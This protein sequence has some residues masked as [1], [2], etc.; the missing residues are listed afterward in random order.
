MVRQAASIRSIIREGHWKIQGNRLLWL[1]GGLLVLVLMLVLPAYLL[2]PEFQEI[3]DFDGEVHAREYGG[4]LNPEDLPEAPVVEEMHEVPPMEEAPV[5]RRLVAANKLPELESRLPR[6]PLVMEGSPEA[7]YGGTLVN[8]SGNAAEVLRRAEFLLRPT[9]V[10]WSPGG[11]PIRPWLAKSWE[12][13]E[14][15]TEWTFHLRRGVQ[16]SD[17]HPLTTRGFAYAWRNCLLYAEG[18]AEN[19]AEWMRT[20]G[21]VAAFVPVQDYCFKLVFKH[22]KPLLLERLTMAPKTSFGPFPAPRH[23]LQ[24]FHWMD[25]DPDKIAAI[26]KATGALEPIQAYRSLSRVDNPQ[27]PGLGPWIY[28]RFKSNPPQSYVRNPY[29]F[30]VDRHGRQLPYIDQL[31]LDIRSPKLLPVSLAAGESSFQFEDI[32]EKDLSLLLSQQEKAGYRIHEWIPAQRS[33]WTIWPNLNRLVHENDPVSRMKHDLLNDVRFR[34]ALSLA[35]NR[36]RIIEGRYHGIGEPAQLSPPPDS[37]LY[38]ETLQHRFTEYA[39]ARAD[40]LLDRIGLTNRDKE[41]YRTFPDGSRMTWFLYYTVD[42]GLGPSA[43]VAEDWKKV[44]IRLMLKERSRS[45]FFQEKH[46]WI[47]DFVA[48]PGETESFPIVQPRSFVPTSQGTHFAVGFA[49]WFQEGGLWHQQG[50]L[51]GRAVEPPPGHPLRRALEI[52]AELI[53]SPEKERREALMKEILAIAAENVWSISIAT[54]LPYPVLVDEDLRGVPETAR[55]SYFFRSPFNVYPER[56]YFEHS[57]QSPGMDRE[58]EDALREANENPLITGSDRTRM[59]TGQ[60]DGFLNWR[61]G[62]LLL[63]LVFTGLALKRYPYIGKRLLIMVPTLFIISLIIFAIIQLPPGS[64]LETRK[65][66]MMTVGDQAALEYVEQLEAMFLQDEPVWKQYA[67]WVGLKWFTTFEERDRGLLQGNLGISMESL[68]PVNELVGDRILLTFGV[69]LGTILFT[70]VIA[71]PVGVY[72][73]VRQYSFGDY[74]FTTL[75]FLGMCIPNFLLAIILIAVGDA[76]FGATLT[77]LFS[78]EYALQPEWTWDKF[79]DLLKHIWVPVL[80]LG[81]AGTGGMIRVMRANLLD[82]MKKPYVTTARA[83]GVPPLKLILKYPVRIAI[84]PFISGIGGIFPALISGGAIVAIV[85]SLP[86]VGPLL[87]D[88]VMNEDLYLAGSLLMVLSTLSVLG[89]LFS[90]ILLMILDPRIRMEKGKA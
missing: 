89:T 22:P 46:A 42:H 68:R 56:F 26:M 53:E 43:F 80:V 73:A 14:D 55:Y 6:E 28:R 10:R 75:G 20:R 4:N 37:P 74:V 49:S 83:K 38:S 47:Q 15:A 48:F 5:L 60:L 40:E 51:S 86:T 67:W 24:P 54:P 1:L 12:R 3:R 8:L 41:G 7:K 88:A 27:L 90:D 36:A 2:A 59:A 76:L 78:P 84:N 9:L 50:P 71:I 62:V 63:L 16:W 79:L 69:S 31:M 64:Y 19:I 57:N 33:N 81:T 18:Q 11:Y 21:E 85:L 32:T 77:G 87:L 65:L 39:P 35:I 34:R 66:E 58:I 61:L 30:A 13:N 23:Y 52:Y 25:G 17:G 44:G 29:Y 72:S 82:E 45:L 70:W